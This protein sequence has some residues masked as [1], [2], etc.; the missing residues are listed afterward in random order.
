MKTFPHMCQDGHEP[1]GFSNGP[2]EELES[3]PVCLERAKLSVVLA[4]LRNLHDMQNGPPLVSWEKDWRA[5]M[6]EAT[7]VLSAH[8]A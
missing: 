4:A 2:A 6:D 7:N 1:I 8:N 5:A 3:C